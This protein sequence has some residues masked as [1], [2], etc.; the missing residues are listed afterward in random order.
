M[1]STRVEELVLH[2]CHLQ[3]SSLSTEPKVVP[4]HCHGDPNSPTKKECIANYLQYLLKPLLEIKI[5]YTYKIMLE[6]CKSVS[7]LL[8]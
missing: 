8:F 7:L 5:S 1:V 4:E 2:P 3:E 6:E